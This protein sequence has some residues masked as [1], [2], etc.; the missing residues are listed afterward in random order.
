MRQLLTT[1]TCCGVLL[2]GNA[3][4]AQGIAGNTL[5]QAQ[6]TLSQAGDAISDTAG[7]ARDAVRRSGDNV[8]NQVGDTSARSRGTVDRRGGGASLDAHQGAVGTHGRVQGRVQ[9]RVHDGHAYGG[10]VYGGQVYEGQV[11]QAVPGHAGQTYES[12]RPHR[13]HH[14][15]RSGHRHGKWGHGKRGHG[16]RAHRGLHSSRRHWAPAH[17]GY[18][19]QGFSSQG[20]N[21]YGYRHQTMSSNAV[22]PLR[23][24]ASGREFICVHGQ[25][26]YFDSPVAQG[27]HYQDRDQQG[28]RYQ[29]AY[30]S[31][32]QAD[33][34]RTEVDA[35][36][37]VDASLNERADLNADVNA[38]ANADTG[39]G[40][41]ANADASVGGDAAANPSPRAEGELD[42]AAEA[43]AL[44]QTEAG[45][46][47][48]NAAETIE[49]Q[50]LPGGADR[51][52]EGGSLDPTQL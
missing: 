15:D 42:G 7:R 24:D 29:A 39:A 2:M 46:A 34:S 8:R 43:S 5:S 19:S 22:Y 21:G 31:Y 50:A 4:G 16:K 9:G 48:D 47:V 13:G 37:N 26:V 33:G 20:A 17:H 12:Y 51:A 45:E 52:L 38:N 6:D 14:Y 41:D 32:D 28:D 10:Q 11:H 35:D 25:P 3:V 30:G 18:H 44:E 40:V 1:A 27:G 49:N 36:T 23:H